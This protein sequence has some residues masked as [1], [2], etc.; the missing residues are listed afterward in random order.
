MDATREIKEI[1]ERL[2]RLEAT[3]PPT[4]LDE[5]IKAVVRVDGWLRLKERSCEEIVFK[6][7][8]SHRHGTITLSSGGRKP[9]FEGEMFLEARTLSALEHLAETFKKTRDC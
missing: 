7:N 2:D 5:A 1:R 6:M 9:Y 4:E 3:L 8:V